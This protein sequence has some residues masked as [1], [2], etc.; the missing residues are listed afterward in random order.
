MKRSIL[1]LAA[2]VAGVHAAPAQAK[3]ITFAG[4]HWRVYTGR[5]VQNQC[6]SSS[7]AFVGP[8]LHRLHVTTTRRCGGG[9]AMTM[10]RVYGQ[11]HVRFRMTR[12][13]AKYAIMLWPDVGTRPEIDFAEDTPGDDAR[14]STSASV[15]PHAGA[16]GMLKR[17]VSGNFATWHTM[18]LIWSPSALTFKL[19][20][21]VWWRERSFVPH[22]KRL[23]M[24]IQTRS[25]GGAA[26]LIVSRLR[27]G[28]LT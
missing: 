28:P 9:V 23:H 17:F 19:D 6:Y 10:G 14:T 1:I 7:H 13:A 8:T 15:H 24:A 20:G 5:G 4:H 25:T 12:G 26:S 2:A 21:H 18:G 16:A 22:V 27:V 11:W 3:A